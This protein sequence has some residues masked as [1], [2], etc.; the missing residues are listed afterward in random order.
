MDDSVSFVSLRDAIDQFRQSP[1]FTG[2]GYEW[3]RDLAK[4]TGRVQLGMASQLGGVAPLS[5]DVVKRGNRWVVDAHALRVAIA[6]DRAAIA[7]LDLITTEYE[8][9]HL[10]VGVG[11]S[12]RTRW[13]AYSVARDFHRKT[14]RRPD[15]YSEWW[16]CNKCWQFAST[17]HEREECHRCRDWGACGRDCTLSE[18]RCDVCGTRLAL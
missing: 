14:W 1:G 15:G 2:G 6:S 4:R 12:L 18:V 13:G 16:V 8:H 9:R 7:E 10:L 5:I 3:W 17:E 11:G